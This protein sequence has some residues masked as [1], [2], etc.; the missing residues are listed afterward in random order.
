MPYREIKNSCAGGEHSLISDQKGLVH[1]TLYIVKYI[2][3][4]KELILMIEGA[5]QSFQT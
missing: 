1:F 5:F 4:K 3:T 2:Y